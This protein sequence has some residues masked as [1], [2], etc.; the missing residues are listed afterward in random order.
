MS[1]FSKKIGGF[2]IA[3]EKKR[4]YLYEIIAVVLGL[5]LL[6]TVI[7]SLLFISKVVASLF[8][9]GGLVSSPGV[10]FDLKQVKEVEKV[11]FFLENPLPEE[12]YSQPASTTTIN[13]STSSSEL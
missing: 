5:S 2:K 4:N 10:G 9:E 6:A 3:I 13:F 1:L 8:L 12:D 7:Y 11:R